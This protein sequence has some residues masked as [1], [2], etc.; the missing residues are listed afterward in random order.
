MAQQL[1]KKKNLPTTTGPLYVPTSK[2]IEH[3]RVEGEEFASELKATEITC[4]LFLFCFN[5]FNRGRGYESFAFLE[6]T[7]LSMHVL[8]FPGLLSL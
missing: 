7:L 3:R 5:F 2:K 1:R 4:N 6:D 8:I